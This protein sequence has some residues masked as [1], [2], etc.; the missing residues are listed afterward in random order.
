MNAQVQYPA[1]ALLRAS[2][3]CRNSKTGERG[4]LPIN[5]STWYKWIKDGKVPEGRKIGG[6][7]TV[8]PLETVLAIGQADAA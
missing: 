5:R 8:W 4:L 6:N 7:T 3:I 1:G 2:D